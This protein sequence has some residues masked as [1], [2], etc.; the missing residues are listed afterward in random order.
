MLRIHNSVGILDQ[1]PICSN[2]SNYDLDCE[3]GLINIFDTSFM[4]FVA[5]QEIKHEPLPTLFK[6][7][8][9]H[10]TLSITYL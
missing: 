8:Q 3:W 2:F 10:Y 7:V 4:I 9:S 6:I 1:D 5:L